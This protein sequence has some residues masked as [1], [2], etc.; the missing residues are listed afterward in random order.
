[1]CAL[2]TY[3]R[4]LA[5]R[6]GMQV[7]DEPAAV[8]CFYILLTLGNLAYTGLSTAGLY[9]C[10]AHCGIVRCFWMIREG[11]FLSE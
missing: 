4:Q 11:A 9:T 3:Y 1:M 6:N 7:H 5:S 2:I 8:P 10:I